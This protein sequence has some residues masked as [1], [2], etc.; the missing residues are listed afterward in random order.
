M[1]IP[2]TGPLICPHC[3]ADKIVGFG[4]K[5]GQIFYDLP[6]HKKPTITSIDRN[7]YR[8]KT[9]GRTFLERLQGIDEGRNLTIRLISYIERQSL[10]KSFLSLSKEVG[11]TEGTIR[12]IFQD[13]LGRLE[14]N[15][16]PI[17]PEILSFDE[18]TIIG[19]PRY[20]VC[21]FARHSIIGILE[22]KSKASIVK[23]LNHLPEN[24][25]VKTVI[26]DI[27]QGCRDAV[28]KLL[29]KAQIVVNPDYAVNT[30]MRI[31]ENIRKMT[32]KKLNAK[33]LRLLAHDRD[34]IAKRHDELC[35]QDKERLDIWENRFK[36]LAAGY[37]RKE[38]LRV[39]L[40]DGNRKQAMEQFIVWQNSVLADSL[41]EYMPVIDSI[42]AWQ[43]EVF[44]WAG[45]PV[46]DKNDHYGAICGLEASIHNK[47]RGY[48]FDVVKARFL[49]VP[50]IRQGKGISLVKIA[51]K[52]STERLD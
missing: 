30:I 37:W 5:K 10:L 28:M 19:R 42:F 1:Y 14:R 43:E 29:P 44:D 34:I 12:N 36:K 26:M 23:F 2:T 22:D 4:A 46:T 11:I 48:S 31:L 52:L 33:E 32:R 50:G 6:H 39:I 15:F 45:L 3:S 40:N 8:C 41:N 21:D 35:D 24:E 49:S 7:R 17:A 25:R 18:I 38:E 20:L 47:M 51:W 27:N 13:Y 9:C 16:N